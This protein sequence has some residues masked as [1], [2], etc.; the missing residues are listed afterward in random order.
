MTLSPELKALALIATATSLMWI[1]YLLSRILARGVFGAMAN[2]VADPP[3]EPAWADRAQRAHANAI[4]NLAV[5]APLALIA[6]AVGATNPTTAAAAQVFVAAR[7]VHYAVYVF[8]IPVLRTLAFVV[9]F[10]CT[11]V[12]AG[13]IFGL[14]G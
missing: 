11:L 4:E 7:L 9:G 5:F 2:P 10:G 6:A 13:S 8:G 14:V 1:P 12:L 3:P